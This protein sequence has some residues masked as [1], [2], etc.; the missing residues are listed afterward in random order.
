MS[1]QLEFNCPSPA[2]LARLIPGYEVTELVSSSIRGALYHAKQI[3]LDRTVTIKVLPPEIG[4]DATLRNAFETE[5]KAMARLNHP[6]LVDVFDFGDIQGM[7]YII[8]EHVPGRSLFETTHGH[9]VDQKESSRL[10]ADLCHGLEHAHQAGI[11]HRALNP[12]NV[13]INNEAQAKIVDF[14]IAGLTGVDTGDE[15]SSYSAPELFQHGGVVDAKADIYSAGMMLYELIVGQLP[16]NPYQPPS[17]VRNCRPELD[18]IIYRAIQPDPA[19]RFE[20]A[21]EM[22]KSIEEMLK[23]MGA[24]P[25]QQVIKTMMTSAA[26]SSASRRPA[27]AIH[28][29]KPSNTP[30]IVVS[31][32]TVAVIIG[33]AAVVINSASETP[34]GKPGKSTTQ[35]SGAQNNSQLNKHDGPPKP[36]QPKKRPKHDRDITNH[37]PRVPVTPPEPEGPPEPVTPP[38]PKDTGVADTPP[39]VAPAPPVKPAPPE[40]D[41]DAW[42]L[43]ARDYMQN[44]GR[45]ILSDYDKAL[46]ANIDRFERDVKRVIRKLDRNL[47]KPA[48]LSAEETFEK[49]R[50]LGRLPEETD[51]DTP[52]HIKDLYKAALLDQEEVDAKFLT[53]FTK[54][55][56]TYIQGL[57]KQISIL[58]KEGNDRHA[59]SLEEE[60]SLT[61]K[62]MARFIR[63]LRGQEPDPEP[64]PDPEDKNEKDKKGKRGRKNNKN[65]GNN[66]KKD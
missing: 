40:F 62:E 41:I 1:P 13:L 50:L 30:A 55:R 27:T 44:K 24:A 47:R 12:H 51:K 5:A 25:T 23:K 11:V 4:Q 60:I 14:G 43:K 19:N 21:G 57:D 31:L 63:I 64:E 45:Y 52:K 2:E 56:I 28:V 7:L 35:P 65:A 49:F 61:Q 26:A 59:D 10:V 36:V 9:H 54:L 3:S 29:A 15:I 34:D 18:Q 22:A 16:S 66:D 58:R 38:E 32:L 17:Q 42:L 46:L 8:M 39:P 33:I 48:E 20:S 53:Q 37:Q 6:N